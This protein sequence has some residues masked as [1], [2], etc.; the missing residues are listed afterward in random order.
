M[1]A[2]MCA[3]M[4]VCRGRGK[5]IIPIHVHRNQISDDSDIYY[6]ADI[7]K[8]STVLFS[9]RCISTKILTTTS[10]LSVATCIWEKKR[11]LQSRLS[12]GLDEAPPAGSAAFCLTA[13]GLTALYFSTATV[14]V[15]YYEQKQH[16]KQMSTLVCSYAYMK[17]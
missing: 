14:T 16:S 8:K 7:L 13:C 17:Y 4:R 3:C 10:M 2:C 15:F 11:C 12:R 1:R 6:H 5:R 9:C